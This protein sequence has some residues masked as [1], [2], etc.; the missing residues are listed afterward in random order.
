MSKLV[1]ALKIMEALGLPPSSV[2]TLMR[3][4]HHEGLPATRNDAGVWVADSGDLSRWA[5]SKAKAG[6]DEDAAKAKA[7][8][9]AA[10]AR[11]VKERAEA[12][13]AEAT[14]I[15]E[16]AE[17]DAA[18]IDAEKAKKKLFSKKKKG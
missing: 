10:E 13:A 4:I 3:Y 6:T 17:A 1:G 11:A 9:D 2:S 8:A 16:R 7:E 15:K 5:G 18:E 12:D 14:A